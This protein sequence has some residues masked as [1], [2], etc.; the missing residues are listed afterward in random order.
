MDT[1]GPDFWT[2]QQLRLYNCPHLHV[3]TCFRHMDPLANTPAINKCSDES[4]SPRLLFS[5]L[6]SVSRGAREAEW[7]T[8]T[9]PSHGA[10]VFT[11]RCESDALPL[12][13]VEPE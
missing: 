13:R 12:V 5:L 2:C 7:K 3:G 9:K 11:D 10:E 8:G 6:E 1:S 4:A